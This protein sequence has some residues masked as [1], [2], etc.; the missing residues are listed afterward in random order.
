M[1]DVFRQART[2][3]IG[4]LSYRTLSVEH[5]VVHLALHAV[6]SGGHRL[7]WLKDLEQ[8]MATQQLDWDAVASTARAWGAAPA[9]ALQARRVD[10]LVPGHLPPAARRWAHALDDGRRWVE[11]VLGADRLQPL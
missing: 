6:L 10:R 4:G 11:L 9:L 2:V 7:G 1:E 8:A 5:E 3:E